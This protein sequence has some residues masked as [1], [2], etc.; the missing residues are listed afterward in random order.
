MVEYGAIIQFYTVSQKGNHQTF[1]KTFSNLNRFS[2]F[3]HCWKGGWLFTTKLR[4]IL[5]RTLSMFLH[6]LGKINSS[7]LLQITTEKIKQR[8]VFDKNETFMLSYGWLEIG[9]LFSTAYAIRLHACMNM[10]APLVNC[11]VNDALVDVTPHLLYTLFQF[12]CA[13][14]PRLVHSLLDD[15]PDPVIN[16]IKVRAVRWPKIRW[17]AGIAW[18]VAQCRVLV[19][20]GVVL[21]K[22]EN[23]PD[24]SHIT[25]SNCFDRSTSQ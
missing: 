1:G 23:S 17:N 16:Q 19:C 20:W 18:E 25:G 4:N 5:Y 6:Y 7:N 12:V 11:I 10:L 15:A 24:T 22:D 13:V 14:H 8:V 3:F 21:L 9:V 2:K